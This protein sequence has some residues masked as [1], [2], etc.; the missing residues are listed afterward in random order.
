MTDKV[1]LAGAVLVVFIMLGETVQLG[2]Q[3]IHLHRNQAHIE[4]Q[5]RLITVMGKKLDTMNK[6]ASR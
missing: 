5:N 6:Q 4:A 2:V 1:Y 3:T